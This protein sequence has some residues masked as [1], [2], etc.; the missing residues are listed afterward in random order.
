[1]NIV[2]VGCGRQGRL[3]LQCL[4]KLQDSFDVRIVGVVDASPDRAAAVVRSLPALGFAAEGV[5]Q[6]DSLAM[7]AGE[8]D[9]REAVVDVVTTNTAHHEVAIQAAAG[10]ARGIVI[11]KPLA[12]TLE[13][14]H[15]LRDLERP[16]YMMEN[17][18][19]SVVTDFVR[20]YLAAN[21]L[22]PRFVKTEFSKDRR[23]D[24]RDGRGM[25]DD[26]VPHVFDVEMPHQIALV[27]HLL[28][29]ARAV[30]DAWCHDMVLPDG[31]IT[32]HGEGAITLAHDGGVTSYNYSNLL[33]YHCLSQTHRTVR[34]YC[35]DDVRI[36]CYYPS[37]VDLSGSV[38]VYRGGRMVERRSFFDDSLTEAFRQLLTCCRDDVAAVTDA[39][40]GCA[41]LD[42]LTTG[43]RLAR[44]HR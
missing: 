44:D 39:Q 23:R 11:E 28:G 15:R 24:S 9:L 32:D 38:L 40:F 8:V 42:V 21:R 22:T 17:Y 14:A 36:L 27:A 12:D 31:R 37:T 34:L 13:H 3:H 35:D 5:V 18:V 4:A 2:M 16:V 29:P 41:V 10:G 7:L 26:Y 20:E 25:L 33:G 30:Y 19:F 1:M 6:G 43:K